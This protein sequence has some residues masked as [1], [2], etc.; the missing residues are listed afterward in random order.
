[1]QTGDR[2][3]GGQIR[4]LRFRPAGDDLSRVLLLADRLDTFGRWL[5]LLVQQSITVTAPT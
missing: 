5:R 1:M 2:P 4:I 3:S